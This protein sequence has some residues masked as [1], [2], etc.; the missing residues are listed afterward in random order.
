MTIR[1]QDMYSENFSQTDSLHI[2]CTASE[3]YASQ[4]SG[5]MPDGSW[6]GKHPL[7]ILE[8]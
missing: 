2:I 7:L 1:N 5:T 6:A 4:A 8:A 3:N